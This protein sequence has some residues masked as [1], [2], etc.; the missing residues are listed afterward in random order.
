[1]DNTEKIQLYHEYLITFLKVS[2]TFMFWKFLYLIFE[3][4][5]SLSK[6]KYF[7]N[8]K[9]KIKNLRIL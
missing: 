2:F 3:Q 8:Y 5:L 1:M 4:M 6:K 7:K 9:N